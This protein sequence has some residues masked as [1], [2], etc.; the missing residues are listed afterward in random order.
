[1]AACRRAGCR[2]GAL[3]RGGCVRVN[4]AQSPASPMGGAGARRRAAPPAPAAD[5][6]RRSL[7]PEVEEERVELAPMTAGGEVVEDYRSRGLTLRSHPVAFLRGDPGGCGY[8]PAGDLSARGWSPRGRRGARARAAAAGISQWR[9]VHHARRRD[10]HREPHHLAVPVRA[11]APAHSLGKH[12]RVS[13]QG[14]AGGSGHSCDC[15]APH[16]LS[17]LLGAVGERNAIFPLRTAEEMKRNTAAAPTHATH[18]DASRRTSTFPIFGSKLR[19]TS[20]REIFG[21]ARV[22]RLFS[23]VIFPIDYHVGR[24]DIRGAA[25]SAKPPGA[26][27]LMPQ[28][29]P[30]ALP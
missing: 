9:P 13:R 15:R 4:R 3:G 18:S 27:A 30:P 19:S 10:G 12:D 6:R 26:A 14:T 11:A 5:K 20:K 22:R 17:A 16:R 7:L 21:E 2:F 28:R 24:G 1:M 25:L 8:V 23:K 29:R